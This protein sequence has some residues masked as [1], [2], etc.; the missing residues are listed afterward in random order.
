M[1]IQSTHPISSQFGRDI[2]DLRALLQHGEALH[3]EDPETLQQL[4]QSNVFKRLAIEFDESGPLGTRTIERIFDKMIAKIHDYA[5]EI[6]EHLHKQ[7]PIL[8]RVPDLKKN[9]AHYLRVTPEGFCFPLGVLRLTYLLFLWSRAI[10]THALWT[11]LGMGWP[12]EAGISF[13]PEAL[14]AKGDPEG[15][16]H[17]FSQWFEAHRETLLQRVQFLSFLYGPKVNALHPAVWQLAT[18]QRLDLSGTALKHLPEEIAKLKN[19]RKLNLSKLNLTRVPKEVGELTQLTGLLLNENALESLPADLGRLI[20]LEKLDLSENKLQEI[21]SCLFQMTALRELKLACNAVAA[22]PPEIG[23]L[24]DLTRL[25]LRENHIERLPAE[26]SRLDVLKRF[27]IA[28]NR[29]SSLPTEIG[30]LQNLKKLNVSHNRLRDL[31]R[32]IGDMTSL[33][34]L[35]ATLNHLTTLPGEIGN[36][37]RLEVLSLAGNQLDHLPVE[38]GQLTNLRSLSLA[39]NHLTSLPPEIGDLVQLDA[40]SLVD[41]WLDQLPPEIGRLTNLDTLLLYNSV[42]MSLA[43]MGNVPRALLAREYGHA[44]ALQNFQ[45]GLRNAITFLPPELANIRELRFLD[46]SHNQLTQLPS[47]F[48]QSNDDDYLERKIFLVGN[49][50]SEDWVHQVKADLR[51]RTNHGENVPLLY[52]VNAH[53]PQ[54]I[55]YAPK[56][57][58]AE[59]ELP[60]QAKRLK[61]DLFRV[62]KQSRSTSKDKKAIS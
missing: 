5:H 48:L 33:K 2:A 34:K 15:M 55:F 51:E 44:D 10:D 46:V 52:N 49:P 12:S 19:L 41:N 27:F 20:S 37:S 42:P 59:D 7:Y 53:L 32:A 6:P 29:L 21:P 28:N 22:L 14:F 47:E 4:F 61:V 57:K 38:I 23:R 9:R 1:S 39:C 36:L 58:H 60:P 16:I 54:A 56:R 30:R 26:I 40:L 31:P 35:S 25:D 13:A 24:T 43:H 50:L 45:Y 62:V 18:L 3:R 8:A 17:A 11:K